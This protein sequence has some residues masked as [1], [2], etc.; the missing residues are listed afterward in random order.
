MSIRPPINSP[1]KT[2]L[3][4]KT[5]LAIVVS[6]GLTA[7]TPPSS[8]QQPDALNQQQLASMANTL[9]VRYQV[10]D[11]TANQGC[12]PERSEGFCFLGELRLTSSEGVQSNDWAMYFS[13]MTPIQSAESKEFTIT[14][15]NGDLH[16]L[17]PGPE[18]KGLAPG[19]TV[20]IP[21]RGSY[22]HLSKTDIMPNYYLVSGNLQPEVIKSTVPQIDPDTGLERLPHAGDFTDPDKQL[23]RTAQDKTL[24]ATSRHLFDR[25]ETKTLPRDKLAH[26]IIPTPE[27]LTL[28]GGNI[29][30]DK[31]IYL[32]GDIPEEASL[33]P[34]LNELK[35]Y[36]V[37][38]NDRG[39]AMTFQKVAAEKHSPEWYRLLIN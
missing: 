26:T 22:W 30:L 29:S 17:E 37:D 38:Q 4:R 6:T 18:F 10:I 3:F 35:R 9:T 24:M 20:T 23:K 31:G 2:A 14:H 16:R 11:N 32:K 13:D 19:Q 33:A 27:Q 12:D 5:A 8:S 36:G 34:P 28:T 15:L 1:L 39:T 25:I 7:C 21:F